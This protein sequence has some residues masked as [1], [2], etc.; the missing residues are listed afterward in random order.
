VALRGSGGEGGLRERPCRA[1]ARRGE[2]IEPNEGPVPRSARWLSRNRPLD[3]QPEA[4][5]NHQQRP[6]DVRPD[7]LQQAEASQQGVTPDQ[8]Q[9]DSPEPGPMASPVR[10]MSLLVPPFAPLLAGSVGW[11]RRRWPLR[12][13][14]AHV[15]I[16]APGIGG[17]ITGWMPYF[18]CPIPSEAFVGRDRRPAAV[19]WP[20][21]RPGVDRRARRRRPAGGNLGKPWQGRS[22]ALLS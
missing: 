14:A 8:D 5:R 21:W 4:K 11:R 3:D 22:S 6:E 2:L 1:P 16:L 9:D 19:C 17:S 13:F 12:W 18:R 20:G 7:P 10:V 15:G